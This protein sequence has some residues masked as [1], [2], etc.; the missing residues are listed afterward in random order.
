MDRYYRVTLESRVRKPLAESVPVGRF[1]S[2]PDLPEGGRRR[3]SPKVHTRVGG[4]Q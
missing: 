4:L 1:A 2:N 3:F